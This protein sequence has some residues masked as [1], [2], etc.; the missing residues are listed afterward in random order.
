MPLY[1]SGPKFV[2]VP[3]LKNRHGLNVT[4]SG[5]IVWLSVNVKVSFD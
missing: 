1:L 3:E 4:Y 5:N 2:P